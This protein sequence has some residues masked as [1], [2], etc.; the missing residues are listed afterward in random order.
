MQYHRWSVATTPCK[1]NW[2][3]VYCTADGHHIKSL[4]LADLDL[5]ILPDTSNMVH[6]EVLN[7]A[8]NVRLLQLP[9]PTWFLP[10]I[11]QICTHPIGPL[12]CGI[13]GQAG[14]DAYELAVK[15][16]IPDDYGALDSL[17]VGGSNCPSA[18]LYYRV[19][20]ILPSARRP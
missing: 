6:L 2:R 12:E 14:K 5:K 8:G 4:S 11:R 10:K 20:S 18:N 9:A 16:E 17:C 13:V 1:D 19:P 7:L 15:G 3:S